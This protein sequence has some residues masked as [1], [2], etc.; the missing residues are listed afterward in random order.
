MLPERVLVRF[1]CDI[2]N[3]RITFA[4]IAMFVRHATKIQV[5]IYLRFTSPFEVAPKPYYYS[6]EKVRLRCDQKFKKKFLTAYQCSS[7]F[8]TR[9]FY[10]F[11]HTSARLIVL[12]IIFGRSHRHCTGTLERTWP[13]ALPS[14]SRTSTITMHLPQNAPFYVVYVFAKL[15]VHCSRTREC[16][17]Q[18]IEHLDE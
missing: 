7:S 1:R 6:R 9:Y 5:A 10:S 12:V 2:M 13:G 11:Q 14:A 18:V 16:S 15:T 17:L 3:E 4:M 8:L